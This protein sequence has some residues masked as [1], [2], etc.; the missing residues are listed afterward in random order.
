[1]K[2]RRFAFTAV[3]AILALSTFAQ[4]KKQ[5]WEVTY[6]DGKKEVFQYD[7]SS[8]QMVGW[9]KQI[10]FKASFDAMKK[11]QG[12][13]G[14]DFSSN[15]TRQLDN[16]ET[17]FG[18]Q[19]EALCKDYTM[20]VY[21]D[22]EALYDCRRGNIS[23][24]L[25]DLR[26]LSVLTSTVSSLSDAAS[27]KDAVNTL[28]DKFTQDINDKCTKNALQLQNDTL[29][30]G[31][32]QTERSTSLTNVGYF[33]ISWS[34]T[35]VP[36]GFYVAPTGGGLARTNTTPV[37]VLRLFDTPA[38]PPRSFVIQD[39]QNDQVTVKIVLGGDV[40]LQQMQNQ[41]GALLPSASSVEDAVQKTASVVKHFY[42][43]S[44]PEV[45]YWI[46]GQVLNQLGNATAASESL[47]RALG[48]NPSLSLHPQFMLDVA[49]AS[50]LK[51]DIG[52]AQ[53]SVGYFLNTSYTSEQHTY[54]LEEPEFYQSL[55]NQ[56]RDPQKAVALANTLKDNGYSW[57]VAVE[58]TPH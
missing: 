26:Q 43:N 19:F 29:D 7:D 20:G 18:L 54:Q 46:G 9:Q 15:H 39:G 55:Y 44:S 45:I 6:P 41:V 16:L 13:G 58:P 33:D 34:A 36:R 50:L 35:N 52:T 3:I 4:A 2:C 12:S 8:C 25:T 56:L 53:K 24:A 32:Q 23:N 5:K 42:K 30:F 51:G 40:A 57:H 49:K 38:P 47:T 17:D 21:K 27:K 28:L 31:T 22:K 11:Y 14:F 37:V 48:T 10:S 1:M